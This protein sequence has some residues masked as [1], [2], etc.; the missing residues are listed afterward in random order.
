MVGF[1]IK[2]TS[3]LIMWKQK[4]QVDRKNFEFNTKELSQKVKQ[5][6]KKMKMED[7]RFFFLSWG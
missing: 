2:K 1:L 6:D 4:N 7:T 3:E 5:K